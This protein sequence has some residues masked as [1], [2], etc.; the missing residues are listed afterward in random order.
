MLAG[1]KDLAPLLGH[2]EVVHEVFE[3]ES[4]HSGDETVVRGVYAGQRPDT[5][6]SGPMTGMFTRALL[7]V[8]DDDTELFGTERFICHGCRI[9]RNRWLSQ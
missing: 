1:F 8:A 9:L 5:V 2:E 3:I 6:V 4:R 7:V